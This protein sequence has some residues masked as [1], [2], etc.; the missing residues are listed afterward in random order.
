MVQEL[1]DS[2]STHLNKELPFVLYR[3]PNEAILNGVF[4]KDS[5]IYSVVDFSET[6]F[7]FAPFDLDF[8][9]I[10]LKTDDIIKVHIEHKDISLPSVD[11]ISLLN[12]SEKVDYLKLINKVL[13]VISEGELDKVVLSRKIEVND[14]V[15]PLNLFQ[16][17][18]YIYPKAFCYI[19]HHP[20][21]GTWVG[22]T[23]EILIKSRGTQF[24]TMSLAGTQSSNEFSKPIW[25]K[26]ELNEQQV[27]TDYILD[28]LKNKVVSLKASEVTSIMAGQLWHLRTEINGVF[29]PNKFG[30]V[31]KALHPTPAVC[32]TPLINAK[33]FIV[34]NENYDRSFY[35][36]FLG[37]LNY[38]TE[39][40]RNKNR[41]NQENSAYRSVVKNSELF[42]NLRCMQITKDTISIYVG[43]GITSDSIPESEWYETVLK[44]NTMFRVLN[45]K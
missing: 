5:Q 34:E 29:V 11:E 23:P 45:H 6:G 13:K 37:E 15:S 35:T 33:K 44:S 14:E 20:K 30:D 4:Q 25:T 36:G 27:V 39:L 43:G 7:V 12:E 16:N 41:R 1:F 2:A 24:T 19:W 26:K 32:G 3:K 28:A 9:P 10:L 17:V 42:V 38:I 22:A 18:L 31:L 8:Q 40:A 21:V